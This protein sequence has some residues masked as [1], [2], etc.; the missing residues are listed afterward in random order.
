MR[1]KLV[2]GAAGVAVAVAGLVGLAGP[3]A[4]AAEAGSPAVITQPTTGYQWPTKQS[5]PVMTGL[6]RGQEVTALCFTDDGDPVNGNRYW[7]RIS[8]TATPDGNTAFVPKDTISVP[9]TT[10]THCFPNNG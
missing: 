10:L 4:A 2:A 3:A 6:E 7:F 9:D 5:P 1:K 8:K